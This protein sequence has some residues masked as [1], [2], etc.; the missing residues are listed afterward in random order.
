MSTHPRTIV[1]I[2]LSGGSGTRLWPLSRQGHPKQFLNLITDRSL[3]QDTV[4]R[5]REV[6][7][8]EAL[9]VICSD[10]H[11]FLVAEQL[12]EMQ[13][14][15]AATILE[16]VGRNTA[17]AL[18][19]AAVHAKNNGDDPLMLVL[20]SD[21]LIPDVGVFREAVRTAAVQAEQGYLVTF[22]IVPTRPEAG[23]GYIR[24]GEVLDEGGTQRVAQFVEKP[25]RDTAQGYLDS[26]G[27]YWNSGMF[28]FKA[29]RYLSE[30]GRQ[31]PQIVQAAT[32]ALDKAVTDL[33]FVRLDRVAFESCPSDS[34]DYAVMEKA[35]AVAV[36]PLETPWSDVGSWSALWE[37]AEQDA[38]G[39][40]TTGPVATLNTRNSLIRSSGRLVCT[41]GADE[42]IVV[43]TPDAVL[44]ADK[45]QVQDVKGLVN[46]LKAEGRNEADLHRK[47]YRPWGA[48]DSIDAA[49]RFQV[50]RIT[51]KPGGCLSL[52]MH[53]HRAEHWVVVRGTARV[54]KGEE[55]MLLTENQSTYIP[56]GVTHRLENPGKIPLDL[57]EVQSGAYLDEDDIIRFEDVYGRQ[58]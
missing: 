10:A 29:S 52:Q 25:D 51:V 26:G 15:A 45:N 18:A 24:G 40:V 36:V 23:Y 14:R 37:V 27:Y 39:N 44:V 49:D 13:A 1:P 34:I 2:V 35:D 38:Q 53:Y 4:D 42:L 32:E 55:E 3:F 16:P 21:H 6:A 50:K 47:V 28:L 54:T 12:M 17:P 8:G 20:P 5:A 58:D 48:Y 7:D 9:R 11:R 43:E 46:L 31:A 33:D 57:I 56:P 19:V 41:V 22:G 30:L